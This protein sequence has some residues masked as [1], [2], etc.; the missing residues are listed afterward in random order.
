MREAA[1]LTALCDAYLPD[2]HTIKIVHVFRES[3]RALADGVFK[4][5]SLIKPDPLRVRCIV[6][7]LSQPPVA[8][9]MLDLAGIA[10]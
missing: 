3:A 5:A 7:T 9:Q 4:T 8:L 6:G 1:N 2:R 10:A